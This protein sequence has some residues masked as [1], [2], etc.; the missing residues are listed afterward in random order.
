MH[1]KHALHPSVTLA[2]YV[3]HA[4]ANVQQ[5]CSPSERTIAVSIASCKAPE[6]G[7]ATDP[8]ACMHRALA[9]CHSCV[10]VSSGASHTAQAAA[11]TRGMAA[12]DMRAA[13]DKRAAAAAV[14]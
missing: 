9:A 6:A 12:L 4:D 14:Q 7:A 11:C 8:K 2:T 10:L 5:Q 3:V 1:K 13:A